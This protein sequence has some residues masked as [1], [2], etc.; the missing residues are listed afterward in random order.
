MLAFAE[1]LEEKAMKSKETAIREATERWVHE[2]NAIPQEMIGRLMKATPDDWCE[3]TVPTKND[4]YYRGIEQT[5][6][7]NY[8]E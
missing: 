7:Q 1:R 5:V 8:E 3:I 4:E 2:M 6:P